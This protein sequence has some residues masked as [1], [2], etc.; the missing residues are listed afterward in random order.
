[1]TPEKK[2]LSQKQT[3]RPMSLMNRDTKILNKIP[4]I[5]HS[6]FKQYVTNIL[7]GEL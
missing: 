5:K 1:M 7:I 2:I 6:S 4:V 3:Y